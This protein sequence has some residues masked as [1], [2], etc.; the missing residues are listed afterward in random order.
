MRLAVCILGR[1]QWTVTSQ[2]FPEGQSIVLKSSLRIREFAFINQEQWNGILLNTSLRN[3]KIS[4][5]HY[6]AICNEPTYFQVRINF[7]HLPNTIYLSNYYHQFRRYSISQIFSSRK[8][9]WFYSNH[10]LHLNIID[11]NILYFFVY[12]GQK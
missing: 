7:T 9:M 10:A 12:K 3:L 5:L 6:F 2:S 4:Q 1:A 8:N 11:F